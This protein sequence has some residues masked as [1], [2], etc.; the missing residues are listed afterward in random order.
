LP[1]LMRAYLG[2]GKAAFLSEFQAEPW[3]PASAYF[4]PDWFDSA[5]R[6]TDWDQERVRCVLSLDPATGKD[7]TRGDES[8]ICLMRLKANK[9]RQVDFDSRR[10]SP[11]LTVAAMVAMVKEHKPDTIAVETVGFQSLFADLLNKALEAE[12]IPRPSIWRVEQ[13]VEKETRIMRLAAP[14]AQGVYEFKE[15]SEGVRKAFDQGKAWPASSH[16]DILDSWELADRAIDRGNMPFGG[17]R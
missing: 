4:E 2:Q 3:D 10:R 15:R 1:M 7:L 16:D 17:L 6:F 13:S 14:L 11:S 5:K 9:R 12:K 8:S